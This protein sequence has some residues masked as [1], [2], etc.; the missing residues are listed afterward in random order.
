MP[1]KFPAGPAP[2]A[3]WEIA[4]PTPSQHMAGGLAVAVAGEEQSC[5][6]FEKARL[7]ADAKKPQPSFDIISMGL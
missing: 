3:D 5:A 1:R 4:K 2:C 6:D 7:V